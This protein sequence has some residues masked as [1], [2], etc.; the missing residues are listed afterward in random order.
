MPEQ[1]QQ[2]SQLHSSTDSSVTTTSIDMEA[3]GM[4]SGAVSLGEL[5]PQMLSRLGARGRNRG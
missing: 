3:K 4:A 2:I 1:E 5:A